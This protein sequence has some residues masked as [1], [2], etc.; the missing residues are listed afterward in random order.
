MGGLGRSRDSA[1]GHEFDGAACSLPNLNFGSAKYP[2]NR[3]QIG[4]AAW[5]YIHTM[6][7]AYPET[8]TPEH[9]HHSLKFLESFLT[10]YPC[11]L[12]SQEFV[13]VCKDLPP[14]FESRDDYV[15]WWCEAHNRVRDDLAQPSV[16]CDLAKL[17]M[18]G[19]NGLQ[20]NEVGTLHA[21]SR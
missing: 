20:L 1:L 6:A 21:Q 3:E 17:L 13:E 16:K 12:C 7:A 18:A 8:P 15:M 2:P 19:C 14:H 4:R 11:R 10:L 9:Q 5:R